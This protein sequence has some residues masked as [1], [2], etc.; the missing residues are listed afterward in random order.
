MREIK[1]RFWDKDE[2]IFVQRPDCVVMLGDGRIFD[3]WR[4]FEDYIES[5]SFIPIQYTGLKDKN[6]KEIYEMDTVR[7]GEQTQYYKGVGNI[8]FSISDGGWYIYW[9]YHKRHILNEKMAKQCEVIGNR[10]EN[11]ELSKE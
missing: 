7:Y 1:F 5:K 9:Y 3:D 2:K 6:G 10:Y 11:P 4:A 8:T